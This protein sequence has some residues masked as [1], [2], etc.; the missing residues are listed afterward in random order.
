M[1]VERKFGR[2]LHRYLITNNAV[3]TQDC[4]RHF[5]FIAVPVFAGRSGIVLHLP[6]FANSDV[7]ESRVSPQLGANWLDLLTLLPRGAGW[8]QFGGKR[9]RNSSKKFS[10]MVAWAVAGSLP[11]NLERSE[12][13]KMTIIRRYVK[14]PKGSVA[15]ATMAGCLLVERVL[16]GGVADESHPHC[17]TK[18]CF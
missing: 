5:L 7:G 13:N 8:T 12:Y 2:I 10:R 15:P 1:F 18:V 17:S 14:I 6:G 9:R 3:R 11:L 4:S 16:A